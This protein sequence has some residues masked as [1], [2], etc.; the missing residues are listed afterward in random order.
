MCFSM[1]SVRFPRLCCPERDIGTELVLASELCHAVCGGSALLGLVGLAVCYRC[2]NRKKSRA[3]RM[4]WR[5]LLAGAS[6]TTGLLL[7]SIVWLIAPDF[8]SSQSWIARISC[9]F[10]STWIHYFCSMLFWAFLCYSLEIDQLFKPNP[11]E[12]F[13]LLYSCLCWGAPSLMCL[14]GLL[15][16]LIPSVTED[17]CDSKNGL[18]VFHDILLYI[19]LLLALFG[20]PFLL[21]RAIIRVPAVL[22]MKFGAYTCCERDKKHALSRRLFQ[23]NGTFIV[24]WLGNV[25]CDF[26]LFLVEVS[27][28]SEPPRQLHLAAVTTF[29]IMGILNPMFCCVHSLAFFGWRSSGA[30]VTRSSAAEE[31]PSGNRL[32]REDS[33]LAEEENLLL[34]PQTAQATGKLSFPN[35]LQ[36]MDSGSSVGK[37]IASQKDTSRIST[38]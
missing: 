27:E 26:M 8:L 12:R 23:I 21:R 33:G 22:K 37:E 13:G 2:S 34:R 29:V 17:R 5:V 15:M 3:I 19:P 16:L 11:S 35:L 36:L 20:S 25:L 30:C 9:V 31:A 14:H 28:T 4:G 10:I 18:I 24:C 1:A 6:V 32:D 38:Y 7:N